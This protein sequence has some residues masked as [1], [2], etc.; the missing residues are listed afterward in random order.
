[1]IKQLI[2][3]PLWNLSQTILSRLNQKP[4]NCSC[5]PKARWSCLPGHTFRCERCDLEQPHCKSCDDDDFELCDDCLAIELEGIKDQPRVN[6]VKAF[7]IQKLNDR[8]R[9]GDSTLGHQHKTAMVQAL[10]LVEQRGLIE[11][12]KNFDKFD[13]ENDPHG[14]HDFGSLELEGEIWYWKIDYFDLNLDHGSD[15]PSNPAVTQRLMTILHSSE[16]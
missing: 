5:P 11:Q 16:Y 10:S 13:E 4:L 1:M 8:F 3:R 12:V 2:D 9:K 7:K 14:E 15:D 6:T